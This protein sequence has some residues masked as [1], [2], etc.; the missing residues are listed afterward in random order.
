MGDY[1]SELFRERGGYFVVV[2][3][4][5]VIE[6]YWLFGRNALYLSGQHVN[7]R[8]KTS[9][10]LYALAGLYPSSPISSA[11]FC[12]GFGNLLVNSSND[13][14]IGVLLSSLLTLL[15][16]AFGCFW[17]IFGWFSPTPSWDAILDSPQ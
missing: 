14:V 16:E 8:E 6:S 12:Y 7:E 5:F 15:G 1:C 4:L 13:G 9:G 10:V 17:Q 2:G 11:A 3:D